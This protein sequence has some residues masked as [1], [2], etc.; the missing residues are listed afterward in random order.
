MIDPFGG[1]PRY[2]VYPY[3]FL[4]WLLI[5]LA[6]IVHRALGAVLALAVL[7]GLPQFIAYAPRG[8]HAID[9]N[10]ELTRCAEA[11]TEY[12][13]SIHFSGNRNQPWGATY[14]R[15]KSVHQYR[16]FT[17]PINAIAV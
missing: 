2:F 14:R 13:F 5:E 9:W 1:G 11:S 6:P 12:K 3:I 10:A 4:G 15:R 8:Y 16:M 7:A 17:G